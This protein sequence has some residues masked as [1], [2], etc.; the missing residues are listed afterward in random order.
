MVLFCF[1][2]TFYVTHHSTQHSLE[3]EVEDINSEINRQEALAMIRQLERQR[4]ALAGPVVQEAPAPR[5]QWAL[6][7]A[8]WS[9]LALPT[10]PVEA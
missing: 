1:L 7:K 9:V 5:P 10:V 3:L 2:F 8:P 6:P 4:P